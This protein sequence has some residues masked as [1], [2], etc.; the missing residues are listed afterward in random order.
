MS[1]FRSTSPGQVLETGGGP[2]RRCA[3]RGL[4]RATVS[5]SAWVGNPKHP[6][7]VSTAHEAH[8]HEGGT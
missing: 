6:H 8:K 7:P 3:G 2:H 5:C 4:R 1:M